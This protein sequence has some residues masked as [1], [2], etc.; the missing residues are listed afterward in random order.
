MKIRVTYRNHAAGLGVKPFG[1]KNAGPA[2][3]RMLFDNKL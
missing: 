2:Q 1:R 3:C